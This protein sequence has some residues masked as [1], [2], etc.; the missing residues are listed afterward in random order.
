MRKFYTWQR[1]MFPHAA[2]LWFSSL[3]LYVQSLMSELISLLIR[4]TQ[5]VYEL[6]KIRS[7]CTS[8]NLMCVFILYSGNGVHEW[9]CLR[10]HFSSWSSWTQRNMFFSLKIHRKPSYAHNLK[11]GKMASSRTSAQNN[12]PSTQNNR[13]R[14]M[15]P[16]CAWICEEK[17]SSI[18]ETTRVIRAVHLTNVI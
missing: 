10:I 17:Y 15:G 1:G 4:S 3:F 11:T 2:L 18:H 9:E 12:G 8:Y 14:A 6:Y 5:R 13:P 7:F 16:G